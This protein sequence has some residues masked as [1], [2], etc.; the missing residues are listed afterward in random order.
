ML[1]AIILKYQGSKLFTFK[2]CLVLLAQFFFLL[3]I[4]VFLIFFPSFI[5]NFEYFL[6]SIFFHPCIDLCLCD[7]SGGA[8]AVTAAAE[9][10]APAG[11]PGRAG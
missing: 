6:S 2:L 3:R 1:L 7:S 10:G 8:S 4:N 11:C 9:S 5:L